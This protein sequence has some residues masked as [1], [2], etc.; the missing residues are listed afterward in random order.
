MKI[1]A[2]L[3][4]N[5][6]ANWPFMRCIHVL[7]HL[8]ANLCMRKNDACKQKKSMYMQF[9]HAIC[10]AYTH[11]LTLSC[12]DSLWSFLLASKWAV[13]IF[14][15]GKFDRAMSDS[16][17]GHWWPGFKG[18]ADKCIKKMHEDSLNFCGLINHTMK[19]RQWL[20]RGSYTIYVIIGEKFQNLIFF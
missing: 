8:L 14:F 2:C 16:K 11:L 20:T 18:P 4:A 13:V 12:P 3:H 1:D 9:M 6:H 19:R 5:W 10:M 15:H 7:M 17:P